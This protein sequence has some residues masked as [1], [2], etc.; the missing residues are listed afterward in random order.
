MQLF[1]SPQI[2]SKSVTIFFSNRKDQSFSAFVLNVILATF[3]SILTNAKYLLNFVCKPIT[4]KITIFDCPCLQT[5]GIE[6]S[7]FTNLINKYII[8]QQC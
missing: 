4:H 5:L 3:A 7:Y 6:Y 1:N 8:H 2:L